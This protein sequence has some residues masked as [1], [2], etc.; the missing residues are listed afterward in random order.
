MLELVKWS[1]AMGNASPVVRQAARF[2]TDSN[3]NEGAL[4]GIAAVLT[5]SAPF[6]Q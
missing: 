6:D 5:R 2:Q 3:N 1:F 4:N